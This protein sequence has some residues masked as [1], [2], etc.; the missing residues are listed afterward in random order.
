[1]SSSKVFRP[2]FFNLKGGQGKTTLALNTAF[3]LDVGLVTNN[4]YSP[5]ED[6]L[7]EEGRVY[8]LGVGEDLPQYAE[9]VSLVF[10]FGGEPD[11][12]IIS[13]IEQC[14]S[15]IVP[16]ILPDGEKSVA[17]RKVLL[18]TL[19]ELSEYTQDIL[20]VVNLCKDN[21][22]EIIK[23]DVSEHFDFPIVS[24]AKSKGLGKLYTDKKSI[25]QMRDSSVLGKRLGWYSRAIDE[26]REIL[27]FIGADYE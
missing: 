2:L 19:N 21:H 18:A 9:D 16:V 10:D 4:V 14:T 1:M 3:E 20:I 11:S 8:K 17:E 6:A 23:E 7:P 15:V 12:R 13:A 22:F 25:R 27:K 5:A 26:Y 24:L